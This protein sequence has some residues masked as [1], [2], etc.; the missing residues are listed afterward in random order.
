[1]T[2]SGTTRAGNTI[3]APVKLPAGTKASYQWYKNGTKVKK[4]TKKSYTLTTKDIGAK[5]QVRMTVTGTGYKKLSLSS[6]TVKISRPTFAV[7]KN[8]SISSTPTVGKTLKVKA[9]TYSPKPTSYSYQWLR[10]G[11]SIKGATKSSYKLA[12]ADSGKSISVKVTAKKNG[13]DNKNATTKAVSVGKVLKTVIKGNG[14]YRVG[15]DLKPG[16]YKANGSGN[17]C[18]WERLNGFGGSLSNVNANHFGSSNVYVHVLAS[19]AGFKTSGCGAWKEVPA[20]GAN[21]T[22]ITKDGNYRVGIDIKPG[23]H[24][25]KSSDTCYWETLRDFDGGLG[26]IIDNDFFFTGTFYVDIPA[27]AKGFGKSGCGTQTRA[28]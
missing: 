8:P 13:Y 14:T 27:N 2:I 26:S 6:H 28:G 17:S 18:Y 10:N 9:E 1:M 20:K 25:G 12:N 11:K 7:K 16:Q 19:D 24:K 15:K 3:S 4:A 5:Y 23:L 21:A 22:K